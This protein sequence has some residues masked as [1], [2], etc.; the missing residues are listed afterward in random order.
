MIPSNDEFV[1]IEKDECIETAGAAK[2]FG[3]IVADPPWSFNDKLK[4]DGKVKRSADSHYSTLN[5]ASIRSLPVSELSAENALCALWVPS[6]FLKAGIDILEEWG[7]DYRQLWIWGKTSKKNPLN[8][9]FGMGRLARNCHEP[10]LIGI[11][12]KYT[13]ELQNR[14]QRNLFMHPT[15]K[16]SQKP[17]S[18]QTSLELMFPDWDKLELFARR[19]RAGWTC[20]GDQA[21][22]TS[23]E[24]I[25]DSM[26]NLLGYPLQGTRI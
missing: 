3:V 25:R 16:H 12:G 14:S 2:K 13:K 23:G 24:D 22:A 21:P 7:F 15:M 11:K 4:F 17:E 8:L 19:Q 9:A 5:L 20:V 10:C 1:I 18:L 6:A 26:G